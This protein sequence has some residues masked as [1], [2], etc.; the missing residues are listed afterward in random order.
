MPIESTTECV[1]SEME[2]Q[3]A[4]R[5][6]IDNKIQL[7]EVVNSQ[8]IQENQYLRSKII[9][10]N[11]KQAIMQERMENIFRV[12]YM[13]MNSGDVMSSGIPQLLNSKSTRKQVSF[14]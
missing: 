7:L 4:M 2:E 10:S 8:V 13:Y 3:Q 12:M 11:Q 1:L 14:F 5:K 9:E 6:E